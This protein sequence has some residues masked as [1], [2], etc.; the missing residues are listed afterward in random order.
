M[1]PAS[2]QQTGE[3][4]WS[5]GS[6]EMPREG[7]QTAPS[8]GETPMEQGSMEQEDWMGED[9]TG[10]PSGSMGDD[11][12]TTLASTRCAREFRCD[13]IGSGKKYPSM[14]V[15]Q[16][17]LLADSKKELGKCPSGMSRSKVQECAAAIETKGCEEPGDTLAEFEECRTVSLCQ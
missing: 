14:E 15:C 7:T 6:S 13:K 1:T 16:S 4:E 9:S 17:V 3:R 8:T 5:E 11:H 10:Q 2:G 12:A